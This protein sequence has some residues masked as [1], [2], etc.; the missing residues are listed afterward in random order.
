MCAPID[1][2]GQCCETAFVEPARYIEHIRRDGAA[3]AAA[4]A[5][6]LDCR[7]PSCPDWDVAALARHVE[8]GHRW[9][10]DIVRR[11]ATEGEWTFEEGPDDRDA[12]MS[13]YEAGL[14]DVVD[15]LS[16]TNGDELVWN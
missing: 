9:F 8:S 11:R 6:H 16:D 2:T 15:A 3:L 4:A 5:G 13:W 1:G 14:A 12:L 7:V 10:A